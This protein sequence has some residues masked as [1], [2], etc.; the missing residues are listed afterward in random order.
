V[1][2]RVTIV[3]RQEGFHTENQRLNRLPKAG[4]IADDGR[5]LNGLGVAAELVQEPGHLLEFV[6]KPCQPLGII[7]NNGLQRRHATLKQQ[8]KE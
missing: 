4:Y 2:S 7:T 5:N 3:G 8:L 1:E 6:Q